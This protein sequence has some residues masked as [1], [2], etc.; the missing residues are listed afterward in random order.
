M[1]SANNS[2]L[3]E[4]SSK[5]LYRQHSL[6]K[7][8]DQEPGITEKL[9]FEDL[10]RDYLFVTVINEQWRWTKNKPVNIYFLCTIISFVATYKLSSLINFN[11]KLIRV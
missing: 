3:P 10:L 9:T 11:S 1:N 4:N 2:K 5:K 8:T 7:K 6:K